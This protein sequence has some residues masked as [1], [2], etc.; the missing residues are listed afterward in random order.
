[1]QKRK[2]AR[3]KRFK[4]KR[5]ERPRER[6][7]RKRCKKRKK[8]KNPSREK[9]GVLFLLLTHP[10]DVL[11]FRTSL[12]EKYGPLDLPISVD[13]VAVSPYDWPTDDIQKYDAGTKKKIRTL[14]SV[15]IETGHTHLVLGAFG[16]EGHEVLI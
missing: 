2:D 13:C 5:K 3:K 4:K 15:A 11:F 1:M 14:L 9:R 7:P 6:E 10:S 8:K 16:C 12:S